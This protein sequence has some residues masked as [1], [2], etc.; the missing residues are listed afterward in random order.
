MSE[1]LQLIVE[2]LDNQGNWRREKATEY[3]ED[4]RNSHVVAIFDQLLDQVGKIKGDDPLL[5][6]LDAVNDQILHLE[7]VELSD[8]VEDIRSANTTAISS[9][10][11]RARY[12]GGQVSPAIYQIIKELETRVR[13]SS[14]TQQ[15]N[16]TRDDE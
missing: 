1:M 14:I 11:G 4:V 8:L 16:R 10:T 7:N 2:D 9:F 15:Q 3:P 6:K 13:G 5:R 12:D